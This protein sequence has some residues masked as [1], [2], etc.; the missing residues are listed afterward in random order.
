ML[1]H[2]GVT[3]YIVF[4]GDHLPSKAT[5]EVERAKRR[6]S[7]KKLGLELYRSGKISQAHQELQKAVDV[8]PYM[9]RL[10]I[11]ELKKLNVQ[12]VVAPYEADAQLVYLE[13]KGLISGILS[14]DSDMLVFGAKRLLTKLEQYGDCVEINRGDFTACRDI[15][16]IGWSDTDFRR[17]AIL[18]GCDYLANINK[19][20]V[21]TAYRYIRRYKSIEKVLQMVQ[22]EGKFHVP[23]GYLED[24][25]QAELTFLHQRIFCPLAKMMVMLTELDGETKEEDLPFIGAAVEQETAIG[26]ACGDLDPMTKEPII[27]RHKSNS[28]YMRRQTVAPD[29][30]L[31]K[32]KKPIDSF[33]IPKRQPLAELDPNSLTPSSSQKRLLENANTTWYSSHAPF[34][35]AANRSRI[36]LPASRPSPSPTVR[37]VHRDEW[38]SRAAVIP[39]PPQSGKRQRLCSDAD[40]SMPADVEGSTSRYFASKRAE[41]SPLNGK[42]ERHKK[43][44]KSDVN[45]WS[46]DSIDEAL[47]QLPDICDLIKPVKI[48]IFSDKK[49]P[50]DSTHST[51]F[52]EED[53]SQGSTLISES[54]VMSTL[55]AETSIAGSFDGN[56]FLDEV[57]VNAKKEMS[58]L[59]KQFVFGNRDKSLSRSKGQVT[60]IPLKHAV[61]SLDT[62]VQSN[63]MENGEPATEIQRSEGIRIHG[64]HDF[65]YEV[66]KFG[67]SNVHAGPESTSTLPATME[68]ISKTPSPEQIRVKET[69]IASRGSEDLLVPN[70]ED[71]VG[72]AISE[73]E[74]PSRPC[75]NIGKFLFTPK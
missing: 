58:K 43:A 50:G 5:T 8:T 66:L 73:D 75:L 48:A 23:A 19:M 55:T 29:S 41:P 40:D 72:E 67:S 53:T 18:S 9:A 57:E 12:Y 26:V 59:A 36:S 44:K 1:M 70:S 10:L 42:K 6:E 31:K 7:S 32:I 45:I 27:I 65:D 69:P 38:L 15:S 34:I 61:S 68:T 64:V 49:V 28:S 47:A 71:E 35:S 51:I 30:D 20:G 56:E 4:D 3:P 14:E 25:K 39:A 52:V 37:S 62:R 63:D 74:N 17:M 24:F 13:R 11:E 2:Y 33:F 22:F 46:D 54:S 21:K 16:L 60:R